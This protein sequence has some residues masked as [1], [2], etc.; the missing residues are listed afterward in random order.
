MFKK[1]AFYGV[2]NVEIII[3]KTNHKSLIF[4]W[5]PALKAPGIFF[6]LFLRYFYQLTYLS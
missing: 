4:K 6:H 2:A 5:I 1:P 3:Y